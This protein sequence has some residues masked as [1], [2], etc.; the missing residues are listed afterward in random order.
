MSS[1]NIQAT[2]KITKL[3]YIDISSKKVSQNCSVRYA[4]VKVPNDQSFVQTNDF[5]IR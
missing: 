1:L 2:G 4:N 5:L 3:L